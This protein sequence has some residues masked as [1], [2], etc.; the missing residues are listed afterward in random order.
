MEI[1]GY[2]AISLPPLNRR[3]ARDL[4]KR[5]RVSRLLAGFRQ[6]PPVDMNLLIDVLL[7]VSNMACE[8]PWLQEMDINPLLGSGQT[9][10]AVD[11]RIRIAK[12]VAG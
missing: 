7:R 1:L 11:A 6:M 8:L 12:P 3:L 2:A 4:I 10:Q 5:T 9:L